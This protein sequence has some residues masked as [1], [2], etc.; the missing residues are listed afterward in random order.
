MSHNVYIDVIEEI[1]QRIDHASQ[2]NQ[3]FPFLFSFRF[4]GDDMKRTFVRVGSK[5]MTEGNDYLPSIQI[6]WGGAEEEY[7]TIASSQ[8]TSQIKVTLRIHYGLNNADDDNI[9][10]NTTDKTGIFYLIEELLDVV[11]SSRDTGSADPRMNGNART[12]CVAVIG[13]IRKFSDKLMVDIDLT[14]G[15]RFFNINQRQ[16]RA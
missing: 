2:N 15:T 8:M 13:E 12:S 4:S 16:D 9:L 1:F 5:Q 11:Y 3:V 7:S 10:Y 6:L 14:I